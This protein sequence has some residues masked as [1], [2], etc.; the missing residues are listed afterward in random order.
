MNTDWGFVVLVKPPLEIWFVWFYARMVHSFSFGVNSRRMGPRRRR[1]PNRTESDRIGPNH[2]RII[3]RP[4]RSTAMTAVTQ[5]D[6]AG[7]DGTG[8]TAA[9]DSHIQE[10]LDAI[11]ERT[12]VF[13]VVRKVFIV[14]N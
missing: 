6:N 3:S 4:H 10:K 13:D 2:H 7:S 11:T 12:D 1:Q 14:G 5:I 9:E 8:G